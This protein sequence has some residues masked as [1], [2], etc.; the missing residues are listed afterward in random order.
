[1][2]NPTTFAPTDPRNFAHH[3]VV[4]KKDTRRTLARVFHVDAD[5]KRLETMAPDAELRDVTVE[6][7]EFLDLDVCLSCGPRASAPSEALGLMSEGIGLIRQNPHARPGSDEIAA[8][9]ADHLE[10]N[11]YRIVKAR[12]GTLPDR[13]PVDP[14]TVWT[15][16]TAPLSDQPDD[17]LDVPMP[18]VVDD[19]GIAQPGPDLSEP[20]PEPKSSTGVNP[21]V[22]VH[23]P[24]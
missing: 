12:R 21:E 18:P 3:Y 10:Y 1:M 19:D 24:A 15:N 22:H 14:I 6:I 4:F 2:S 7:I 20:K 5:C 16:E 8:L 11:G 23:D 17:E 13:G 9:L